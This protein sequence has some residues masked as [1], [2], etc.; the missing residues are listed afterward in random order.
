MPDLIST[1]EAC[2]IL[3]IDRSTLSR[4]VNHRHPKILPVM[5]LSGDGRM[6]FDRAA[7]EALADDQPVEQTA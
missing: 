4:W 7:V 3:G 2:Q 5:Q 6:L 1:V